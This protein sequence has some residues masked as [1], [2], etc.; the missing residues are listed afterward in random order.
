M[1]FSG[2]INPKT[3]KL[4]TNSIHPVFSN[5]RR[6]CNVIVDVSRLSG[7]SNGV[8][9]HFRKVLCTLEVMGTEKV[10]FVLPA[11][12][13]DASNAFRNAYDSLRLQVLSASSIDEA[14]SILEQSAHF[15]KA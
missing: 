5:M 12:E 3:A 6:G 11:G 9:F 7:L 4:A 10:I 1:I 8:M 2:I 13:T 15:L 14:E